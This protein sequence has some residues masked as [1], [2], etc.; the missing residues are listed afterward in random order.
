M[1]D[2]ARHFNNIETLPIIFFF[3]QG[4]ETTEIHAI[5]REKLGEHAPSYT[6]VKN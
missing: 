4:K 1:S 2:D 3:L 6:T 5:L